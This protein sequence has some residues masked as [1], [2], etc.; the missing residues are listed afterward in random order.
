M[1]EPNKYLVGNRVTTKHAFR[2]TVSIG[3]DEMIVLVLPYSAG[4]ICNINVDDKGNITLMRVEFQRTDIPY[5]WFTKEEAD[6]L[7]VVNDDAGLRE[8]KLAEWEAN[9][10]RIDEWSKALKEGQ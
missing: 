6:T 10:R 7:F 2:R 3:T 4:H 1:I 9:K 8:A 5:I